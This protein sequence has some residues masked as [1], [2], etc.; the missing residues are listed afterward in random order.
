MLFRS[1]SGTVGVGADPHLHFQNDLNIASLDSN[2]PATG[3]LFDGSFHIW[4]METVGTLIS[5]RV[6]G[7]ADGSIVHNKSGT[8]TFNTAA[9]GA[10][11]RINVDFPW[12]GSI[13]EA[14]F[15]DEPVPLADK[16]RLEANKKI[17]WGTP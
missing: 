1:H 2:L 15:F 11:H 9:L 5:Q 16:Q 13:A 14:I 7:S 3:N 6:D 8:Y 4:G 10:A 17:F 12:S